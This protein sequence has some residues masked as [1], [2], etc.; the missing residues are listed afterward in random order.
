MLLAIPMLSGTITSIAATNPAQIT[1]SGP[2]NLVDGRIVSITGTD[3][4]PEIDNIFAV[5][6]I[7]AS[8]FSVDASV[9]STGTTGS[10]STQNSNIE[11]IQACFNYLVDTLNDDSG[12]TFNNYVNITYATNFEVLI[13]NINKNTNIVQVTPA[14]NLLVGP[15]VG[16]EAIETEIIYTPETMEDPLN[17]KHIREATIMFLNKA[18]TR[19][20]AYY[21]TD[22]LPEFKEVPFEGD[23]NGIFGSNTF[24]SGYFGGGSHGA[25]FRTYLP[26]QAQRNRYIIVRFKHRIAREIFGITGVTLTGQTGLSSRAYRG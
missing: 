3:S 6:I 26:R 17:F 23:G 13:T 12:P 14:I 10:F 2:H 9:I 25:P 22:L 7:N 8:V 11:D 18:F 5:T 21:S 16:Y 20:T 1:T 19:A 4:T 24:G 15:I